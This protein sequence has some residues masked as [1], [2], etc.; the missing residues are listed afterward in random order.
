MGESIPTQ[1]KALDECEFGSVEFS[2]EDKKV[3][4]LSISIV[5]KTLTNLGIFNVP[6]R[7]NFEKIDM[8]HVWVDNSLPFPTSKTNPGA[9][10]VSYPDRNFVAILSNLS[11]D[12]KIHVLVH[13]LFHHYGRA[14]TTVTLTDYGSLSTKVEG[15]GLRVG[16]E[17][18][19]ANVGLD[20]AFVEELTQMALTDNYEEIKDIF[21]NS[22]VDSE[23]FLSDAE[24]YAYAKPRK[25]LSFVIDK[26]AE[27]RQKDSLEDF[28]KIKGGVFRDFARAHFIS[29][30]DSVLEEIRIVF[31]YDSSILESFEPGSADAVFK[32]L[33]SKSQGEKDLFASKVLTGQQYNDYLRNVYMQEIE[34]FL[35]ET[36]DASGINSKDFYAFS[37]KAIGLI[38]IID[39]MTRERG[40]FLEKQLSEEIDFVFDSGGSID[41]QKV[42]GQ[43]R[44]YYRGLRNNN[45]MDDK[46]W[47]ML[48]YTIKYDGKSLEEAQKEYMLKLLTDEQTNDLIDLRE[49]LLDKRDELAQF[50]SIHASA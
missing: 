14:L 41:E 8:A 5:E 28:E 43:K 17:E 15:A 23:D 47:G 16:G 26:L 4:D 12:K 44:I 11:Y 46:L 22:G 10:G 2:T 50:M 29:G 40:N 19:N 34:A 7:P 45:G 18:K 30:F 25:I 38:G 32:F 37:E 49:K 9:L 3:F 48:Q 33:Q 39:R 13:E 24:G 35:V 27:N 31:A 6:G 42:R 36:R 20:E 1:S 21:Q